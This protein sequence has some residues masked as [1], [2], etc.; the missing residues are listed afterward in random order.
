MGKVSGIGACA[1]ASPWGAG[2]GWQ[3]WPWGGGAAV[4]SLQRPPLASPTP[5]S[6]T[7]TATS[8]TTASPA[9]DNAAH[10]HS[11]LRQSPSR[12]PHLWGLGVE[13]QF[14]VWNVLAQ[15]LRRPRRC[16]AS[17]GEVRL[18][19]G[20]VSLTGGVERGPGL[21][22]TVGLPR[23]AVHCGPFSLQGPGPHRDSSYRN[24]MLI[25]PVT[26]CR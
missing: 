8:S 7:V 13:Q 10:I 4:Q 5:G 18:R 22:Q 9:L 17:L 24:F 20:S 11:V 16:F 19:Y 25:P 6:F 2:G 1:G 12:P 23:A 26:S 3:D 15:I 21:H 14:L